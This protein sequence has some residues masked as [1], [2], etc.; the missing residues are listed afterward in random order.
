MKKNKD[1]TMLFAKKVFES[2]TFLVGHNFKSDVFFTDKQG[3]KRRLVSITWNY[4]PFYDPECLRMA[5]E[6]Q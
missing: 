5:G 3:K 2:Q 1:I 4:Y 6:W